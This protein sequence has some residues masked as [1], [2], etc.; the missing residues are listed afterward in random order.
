M[1]QLF[2]LVLSQAK[3]WVGDRL[4]KVVCSRCGKAHERPI[5]NINFNIVNCPHCNHQMGQIVCATPHTINRNHSVAA[6]GV[7]ALDLVVNPPEEKPSFE[8]SNALETINAKNKPVVVELRFQTPGRRPFFACRSDRL[9]VR[10]MHERA[11]AFWTVPFALVP[12]YDAPIELDL[13]VYNEWSEALDHHRRQIDT[14]ELLAELVRIN[15]ELLENQY[16]QLTLELKR[17]EVQRHLHEQRYRQVV[18]QLS[19]QML[20]L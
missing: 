8:I 14:I 6:A 18:L 13:V 12:L 4:Q 11:R 9:T 16:R 1:D 15:I 7:E 10:S 2:S 5:V 3:S 20:A 17:L 19:R